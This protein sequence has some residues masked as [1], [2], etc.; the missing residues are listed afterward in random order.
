MMR[1]CAT[2]LTDVLAKRGRVF[3]QRRRDMSRLECVLVMFVSKRVRNAP[4][5][6]LSAIRVVDSVRGAECARLDSS[7]AKN[8]RGRPWSGWAAELV[9]AD[10]P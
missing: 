4:F 3:T 6:N 1:C 8:D 5:P 7:H 10:E 2:C 9:R